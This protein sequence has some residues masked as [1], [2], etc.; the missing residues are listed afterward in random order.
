MEEKEG[1]GR[2]NLTIPNK[3]LKKGERTEKGGGGE[4]RNCKTT[5]TKNPGYIYIYIYIGLY[6]LRHPTLQFFSG[7][8]H[9]G[10]I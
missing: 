3:R 6:A 7:N 5:P 9:T 10:F 1:E 8:S 4:R 2:N